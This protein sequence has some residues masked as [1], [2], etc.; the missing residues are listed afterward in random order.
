M[1]KAGYKFSLLTMSV[2][3]SLPI[4]AAPSKSVLSSLFS[5]TN[6]P[7]VGVHFDIG[8]KVNAGYASTKYIDARYDEDESGLQ[9]LLNST[10][11]ETN[12][13]PTFAPEL[14]AGIRYYGHKSFIG[15]HIG[16]TF[17]NRRLFHLTY[18]DYY[19]NNDT[20]NAIKSTLTNRNTLYGKLFWGYF[21]TSNTDLNISAL[22]IY[23]HYRLTYQVD[24]IDSSDDTG[25]IRYKKNF[26]GSGYGLGLG[27]ERYLSDHIILSLDYTFVQHDSKNKKLK[28]VRF[29]DGTTPLSIDTDTVSHL[30]FNTQEKILSLGLT[31]EI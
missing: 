22:S 9:G 21:I 13:G 10:P 18:D 17:T 26:G 7:G 24:G 29:S 5:G 4:I 25:S 15:F 2:V 20:E 8:M 28:A 11:I 19:S 30:D 23:N 31:V 6:N 3:I 14:F 27:I 1:K 12:Q 16:D